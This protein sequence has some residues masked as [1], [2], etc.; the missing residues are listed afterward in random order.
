MRES[1]WGRWGAD[2]ERGALNL[3]GSAEVLKSMRLVRHGRVYQLG[4]EI[5]AGSP[6]FQARPP[7]LHLMLRHGGDYLAGA[8]MPDNT[9]S[10]DEYIGLSTHGTTHIDALS[11][12]WYDDALYNGVAPNEVRGTGAARNSIDK[13]GPIIGR[14]VLLDIARLLG[15]DHLDGGYGISADEL[16]AC[17][18]QQG[19]EVGSGDVVL[20]RTGWIQQFQ[21]DPAVYDA[22]QPGLLASTVPWFVERDIAA[23]GADNMTVECA[24]DP[25]GKTVP[26]HR[27]MIRDYGVHL[28]EL[29]DL[30]AL[31]TDGV[32][33]FLFIASPLRIKR[34]V[35][36]PLNPVAVV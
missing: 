17:A 2:D 14:G 22:S 7:M 32:T 20:I 18:Q 1:N 25:T 24:P 30:E 23:I 10:A 11:H 13:I 5:H 36:S 34:G 3:I 19:V 4:M 9:G 27:S 26:F 21:K 31:A 35:G 15:V 16:T 6:R 33:E 28:I 29:L 12:L 8:R